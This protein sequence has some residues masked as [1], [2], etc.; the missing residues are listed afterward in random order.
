MNR[1]KNVV[2][3]LIIAIVVGSGIWMVTLSEVENVKTHII[4]SSLLRS[5]GIAIATLA[6]ISL[7]W[8][9]V[10]QRYFFERIIK[11]L[12]ISKVMVENLEISEVYQNRND[13]FNSIKKAILDAEG[14]IKLFG[15]GLV[16]FLGPGRRCP[17]N[18]LLE[19]RKNNKGFKIKIEIL[20]PEPGSEGAETRAIVDGKITKDHQKGYFKL[21]KEL[22]KKYKE[23]VVDVRVYQMLPHFFLLITE[24]KLFWEPY[25]FSDSGVTAPVFECKKGSRSYKRYEKHFNRIWDD[26]KLSKSIRNYSPPL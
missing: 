3:I 18:K 26:E 1:G 19:K 21:A 25:D 8:Q 15:G 9:L 16:D 17:L 10:S 2:F 14:E 11:Y 12:E 22:L 4:A 7:T 5:L 6:T 24:N 13:A 20:I 23:T